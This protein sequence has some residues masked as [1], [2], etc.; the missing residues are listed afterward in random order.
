MRHPKMQCGGPQK[1][2]INFFW[3]KSISFSAVKDCVL[4]LQIDHESYECGF[5]QDH[6]SW[7][8]CG[9]PIHRANGNMRVK[10]IM[11]YF[12]HVSISRNKIC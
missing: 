3:P 7:D 1:L 6:L 5:R 4:C 8:V 12:K 2:M 9:N 11:L 10:Q